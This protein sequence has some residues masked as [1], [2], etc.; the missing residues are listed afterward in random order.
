MYSVSCTK[1]TKKYFSSGHS[2]TSLSCRGM[3]RRAQQEDVESSRKN[4]FNPSILKGHRL[5]DDGRGTAWGSQGHQTG[6]KR[7]EELGMAGS[8]TGSL[9]LPYSS[10]ILL[11]VLNSDHY[12]ECLSSSTV[13]KYNHLLSKKPMS[14]ITYGRSANP[15]WSKN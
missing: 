3:Y 2:C 8:R 15:I 4:L 9:I 12:K 11:N 14:T 10:N 5:H 1:T 7:M 6:T 13:I